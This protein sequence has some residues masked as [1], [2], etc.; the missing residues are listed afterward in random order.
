M[1]DGLNY[2]KLVRDGRA[3][4]FG[5]PWSPEENEALVAISQATGKHFRDIAPFVRN[6]VLSVEDYQKAIDSHLKPPSEKEAQEMA[7]EQ[8]KKDLKGKKVKK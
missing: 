5:T 4:S 3:K 2:E 1:S 6:G 8:F 7:K